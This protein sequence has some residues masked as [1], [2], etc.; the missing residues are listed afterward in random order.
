MGT[1]LM[2]DAFFSAEGGVDPAFHSSGVGKMGTVY[3]Q[4]IVVVIQWG[5]DKGPSWPR[6]TRGR[7]V[8]PPQ[9]T[10]TTLSCTKRKT[11]ATVEDEMTKGKR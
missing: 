5:T 7:S 3:S 10:T 11:H 8:P 1:I 6:S 2:Q 9:H 4:G